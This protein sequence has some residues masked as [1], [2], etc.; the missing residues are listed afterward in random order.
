MLKKRNQKGFTLIEIIAVLIILGILAAVALP[1]YFAMQDDARTAAIDGAGA[2]GIGN[3]N[4]A[5]AKFVINGGSNASIS[6]GSAIVGTPSTA[7]V[8]IPTGL[9]DF[10]ASYAGE[11]GNTDCNATINGIAASGTTWA[12][13]HAKRVKTTRCP[14]SGT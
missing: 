3:I 13:D 2:A 4:L 1:R 6:G 11:A 7:S 8:A 5:Y 14:W 10:T 12:N 9:G